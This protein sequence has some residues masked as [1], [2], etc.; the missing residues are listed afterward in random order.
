MEKPVVEG[1]PKYFHGDPENECLGFGKKL[2]TILA[3]FDP[4]QPYFDIFV[5]I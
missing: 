5:E 4:K 3:E 1:Y 2:I